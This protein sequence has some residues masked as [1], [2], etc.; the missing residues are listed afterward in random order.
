M[1]ITLYE[2]VSNKDLPDILLEESD[3]ELMQHFLDAVKS[4]SVRT[5]LLQSANSNE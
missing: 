4:V 5:K 2:T 3:F 1:L